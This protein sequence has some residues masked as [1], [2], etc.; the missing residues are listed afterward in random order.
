MGTSWRDAFEVVA[1][2]GVMLG[3]WRIA[4]HLAEVVKRLNWIA[5]YVEQQAE[6]AKRGNG[7]IEWPVDG[8][9]QSAGRS[10]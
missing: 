5:T 3:V 6:Q 2:F 10:S 9:T 4:D 7:S 8:G 1:G